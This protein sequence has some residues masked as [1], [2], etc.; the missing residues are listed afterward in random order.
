[1]ATVSSSSSDFSTAPISRSGSGVEIQSKQIGNSSNSPNLASNSK[2]HDSTNT[3]NKVKRKRNRVPLSCTIC[4]KRKVKCDK[5][6][7]HCQQCTKT[8]VAHLC[9]YM[10]QSWA[11][12]AEKELSKETELKMLRDRVK[13]LEKT[14]SKIHNN[15]NNTN[16]SATSIDTNGTNEKNNEGN[17]NRSNAI[18]ITNTALPNVSTI[19][20]TDKTIV[21]SAVENQLMNSQN[22]ENNKVS[23]EIISMEDKQ[24]SEHDTD[25]L[26]LTKQFDMLHIKNNGTIHLGATHWLAIMKGDP[27]LKL[28]WGHIFNIRGKI[29][30]WYSQRLNASKKKHGMKNANKVGKCPVMHKT[31]GQYHNLPLPPNHP[32]LHAGSSGKCPVAHRVINNNNNSSSSSNNNNPMINAPS[33]LPPNH[34][35]IDPNNPNVSKC[36]VAHRNTFNS[37][38]TQGRCPVI[39]SSSPSPVPSILPLS[40][41]STDSSAIAPTGKCPVDHAKI[42]ANLNGG[43]KLENNAMGLSSSNLLSFTKNINGNGEQQD[44]LDLSKLYGA[45]SPSLPSFQNIASRIPSSTNLNGNVNGNNN[46][47]NNNNINGRFKK[48]QPIYHPYVASLSYGQIV[49]RLNELLPPKRIINLFVD[50]FFKHIY[51]TIPIIDE[52]NFKNHVNQIIISR[53]PTTISSDVTSPIQLNLQKKLTDYCY[54]GILVII[55][56]LTWLSLPPNSCKLDLG[57]N[58]SNSY[59]IPNVNSMSTT[60]SNLKEDALLIKYETSFE[61]LELVKKYLIKFDEIA[62]LSNRNINLTTIQFAIFYKLYTTSC[63]NSYGANDTH[64][65]ENNQILLSSTIQMAFSC[66]LHRDPDNFPQLS[67]VSP[68]NGSMDQSSTSNS[69]FNSIQGVQIKS[70]SQNINKNNNNIP[71]NN[72]N[73]NNNDAGFP[74]NTGKDSQNSTERFKHTWRKIWYYIVQLDVKQSLSLGTPRLLRNLKDFSDTKLPSSSKIDYVRDIKELIIIK[75]FTLFWQIDLCI[76][77]VLNHILNISLAKNVRKFELDSLIESLSSLT[78][79]KKNINEVIS[80]LINKGLLPTTEASVNYQEGDDLYGLP[81]L[82][83][84]MGTLSQNQNGFTTNSGEMYDKKFE[85]PHESTTRALF[86]SKH[87]T[88]RM[89]LYLLNY[90][91]FTHYEPMDNED[92]ACADLAKFY[93]QK[94]LNFAMDGFRN[95][96]IFFNNVKQSNS[97]STT[98]EYLGTILS[99]HCLDIGNRALQFI[100]CLLIR[101][102]CGPLT[103]MK[104]SSILTYSSGNEESD[105][106]LNDLKKRKDNKPSEIDTE[107]VELNSNLVSDLDINLGDALIDK[108]LLRMMLF[109]KLT[110]QLISKYSYARTVAKSTG[111]FIT[112]L[113]ERQLPKGKT[114]S[115]WKHP[116]ITD[117]FKNVP[118]LVLS[119]DTERVKRCPVYQDALG[120]IVPR[121]SNSTI[122]TN[123]SQLLS[124][125]LGRTQLP[126]IRT[127]NPITYTD[128]NLRTSM[129]TKEPQTSSVDDPF[130]K[131]RKLDEVPGEQNPLS[132]FA[133]SP[134]PPLQALAHVS[135][136]TSNDNALANVD[137]NMLSS[138]DKISNGS[139]YIMSNGQYAPNKNTMESSQLNTNGNGSGNNNNKPKS[140]VGNFSDGAGSTNLNSFTT[141]ESDLTN[142]PDFEDFLLQNSNFNGL[143]INP[144]SLVEAMNEI[145]TTQ[146]TNNAASGNNSTTNP[147]NLNQLGLNGMNVNNNDTTNINSTNDQVDITNVNGQVNNAGLENIT[148]DINAYMNN[149]DNLDFFLPFDNGGLEDLN[150]PG[151]FTLWD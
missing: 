67:A 83:E 71:R 115:G 151:E 125:K 45:P 109:H 3:S 23:R 142:T 89:L 138:L 64:D 70:E 72:S 27:Y 93:A 102:K 53:N 97:T 147:G 39:H 91:L 73:S 136:I 32:P 41:S 66:G 68:Q 37:G 103:G 79:G 61:A 33:P 135:S 63:P 130:A 77:A 90:I 52:L 105:S 13:S 124:T 143:F 106:E 144:S 58:A 104:E 131:R 113:N 11:E 80:E 101:A 140:I 129:N 25:E 81:S 145:T 29:N 107:V 59:L 95:C 35:P 15:N 54:L 69:N 112:L 86:F 31:K 20:S 82:E 18:N 98:F 96:L 21:S 118:S 40:N 116:K 28:L 14:L 65:N 46:N 38:V 2:K 43:V 121:S 150:N 49:E 132:P 114:A 126:P 75:N 94:S 146:N 17:S 74:A 76:I 128:S 92:K 5:I 134:L 84:I 148:G 57:N 12:E 78:Y 117:F 88:L 4:R 1:M 56:R 87:M 48:P 133:Q 7:P 119:E 111:F 24:L 127:Y 34:P 36:P 30:E 51:P 10:E 55:L 26:D 122:S 123:A 60:A 19:N 44:N 16:G 141:P 47:N 22:N 139:R 110:K 42:L 108:L 8:G 100:V 149:L 120:F 62:S 6:R 99:P 137:N 85:S 50:K 9:H